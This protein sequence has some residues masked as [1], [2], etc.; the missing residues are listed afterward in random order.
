MNDLVNPLGVTPCVGDYA[1]ALSLWHRQFQTEF[2]IESRLDVDRWG[3]EGERMGI[4]DQ[5]ICGPCPSE[6]SVA[7]PQAL[8]LKG[9]ST[10]MFE[11][12]RQSLKRRSRCNPR[13]IA[14]RVPVRRPMG[15]VA[16]LCDEL[17]LRGSLRPLTLLVCVRKG[18]VKPLTEPFGK[19]CAGRV[20]DGLS[21]SR[22]PVNLVSTIHWP[23]LV[24]EQVSMKSIRTPPISLIRVGS[25]HT[26][27]RVD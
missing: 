20:G 14:A 15:P 1:G 9:H 7:E 23:L 4:V 26:S 13:S 3:H 22:K 27:F 6:L 17:S 19:G 5:N 21:Y 11:A 24:V 10:S 2:L 12:V 16:R 18:S 25:V 8:R